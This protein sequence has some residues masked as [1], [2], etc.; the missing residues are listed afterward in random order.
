[1]EMGVYSAC[2]NSH[3]EWQNELNTEYWMWE[4]SVLSR[5]SETMNSLSLACLNYNVHFVFTT[6]SCAFTTSSSLPELYFFEK[7]SVLISCNRQTLHPELSS[8]LLA[9]KEKGIFSCP[10]SNLYLSTSST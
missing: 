6:S 9:L 1:M 5:A 10:F 3:Q 7:D 8:Q 2:F 4:K